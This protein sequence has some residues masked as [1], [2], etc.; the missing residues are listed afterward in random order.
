MHIQQ[1]NRADI[2]GR[3]AALASYLKR[4]QADA[5]DPANVE[6]QAGEKVWLDMEDAEATVLTDEQAA[7]L[8]ATARAEF[9]AL[10]DDL[11]AADDL[12]EMGT[13]IGYLPS[14][15]MDAFADRIAMH[16]ETLAKDLEWQKFAVLTDVKRPFLDQK[17]DFDPVR[18]AEAHLIDR[19]FSKSSSD[20]FECDLE[21]LLDLLPHLFWIVRCNAGAPK[22]QISAE[23][24]NIVLILCHRANI[25]FCTY[26]V[27][28][29]IWLKKTL[30]SAGFEIETDGV[31]RD[32]FAS[33]SGIEG[34]RLD[35]S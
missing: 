1:V 17:N 33:D 13:V 10:R 34:R 5:Y 31:C 6:V 8:N 21:G 35:L 29:K 25:H 28:E 14:P 22:L 19:G 15:N 18:K 4:W 9:F 11:T 16:F 24:T 12:T 30:G 7:N 3:Y 32:R 27:R 23:G 20:G 26:K 2:L